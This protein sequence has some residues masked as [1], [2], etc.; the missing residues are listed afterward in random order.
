MEGKGNRFV[1]RTVQS[2]RPA[3]PPE[4][5]PDPVEQAGRVCVGWGDVPFHSTRKSES[6]VGRE[7][8]GVSDGGKWESRRQGSPPPGP[9]APEVTKRSTDR[10]RGNSPRASDG[11]SLSHFRRPSLFSQPS[12]RGEG[13][14][15]GVAGRESE[16]GSTPDLPPSSSGGWELRRRGWGVEARWTR[17]GSGF[18]GV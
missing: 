18:R 5:S 11:P 4:R 3:A 10:R 2:S 9:F 1:D 14:T 6:R 7:G 16:R 17:G 13:A 12:P 15:E 8:L